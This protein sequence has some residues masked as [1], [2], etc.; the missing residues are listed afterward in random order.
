MKKISDALSKYGLHDCEIDEILFED[1]GIILCLYTGV[2]NFDS[3]GTET[4]QTNSCKIIIEIE[5]FDIQ[6]LYE[7]ISVSKIKHSKIKDVDILKFVS[8][9][10]KN[11]FDIYLNFY[12]DFSSMILFK[13]FM[14]DAMYEFS[15]SEV[16]NINF[17]F[18]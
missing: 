7:H 8:K 15:I 16:N 9:V 10:K 1:K 18:E 4:T 13:G 11:K 14:D 17:L 3:N 5:N 6:C 12:S 2:Y